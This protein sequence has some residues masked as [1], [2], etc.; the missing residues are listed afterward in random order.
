MNKT[1][2]MTLIAAI[3]LLNGCG[4][5]REHRIRQVVLTDPSTPEAIRTAID[6]K[7]IIIGMTQDQ[8]IAAWGLPCK[9]CTGTRK[10]TGG[11]TWEY[12]LFGADSIITG[13]DLIGPGT[14]TYLFFDSDG[15]LKHRSSPPR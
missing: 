5:A 9:W 4:M 1:L 14:G 6:N 10:S 3:L 8:V 2:L 15:L 12:N 13:A 7:E 11:D